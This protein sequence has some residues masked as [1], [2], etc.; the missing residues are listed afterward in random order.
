[1]EKRGGMQTPNG[2]SEVWI[3]HPNV[4]DCLFA[5][6][7]IMATIERWNRRAVI[8]RIIGC[9]CLPSAASPFAA[10]AFAV[11]QENP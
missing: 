3:N 6:K 8:G 5:G 1:M 9:V 11:A 4:N 10:A 2:I 7:V